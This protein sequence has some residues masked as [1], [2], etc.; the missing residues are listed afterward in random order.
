MI[1]GVLCLIAGSAEVVTSETSAGED[2]ETARLTQARE[3]MMTQAAAARISE[4]SRGDLR[5]PAVEAAPRSSMT[6]AASE[7]KGPDPTPSAPA[8]YSFVS[9]QGEMTREEREGGVDAGGE[10]PLPDLDWLGAET[11]IRT[12]SAQAAA[13]G[14]DWSFGWIRLAADTAANDL[15]RAPEGKGARIVGSSGVLLSL[16]PL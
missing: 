12:L 13:A 7:R 1:L 15:A 11:S 8:G 2:R 5:E 6:A 10:R 16:I 9:Y 3:S 4:E 14:R